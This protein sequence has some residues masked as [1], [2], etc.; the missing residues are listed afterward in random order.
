[1]GIARALAIRPELLVLDEPTSAL[2]PSVRAGILNL[3]MD[4]QDT[5]GIAS[6][7]I[8]HDLPTV[9]HVCD[10]VLTPRDGRLLPSAR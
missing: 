8:S 6:L 5:L 9:R 7:S 3:L 10:R 1:M 4:L 2:D